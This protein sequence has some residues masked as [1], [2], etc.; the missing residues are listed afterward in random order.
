MF[1]KQCRESD[2]HL[3]DATVESYVQV[4]YLVEDD[5]KETTPQKVIRS[6]PVVTDDKICSVKP[7][8]STKPRH[9]PRTCSS[10]FAH[11]D[12]NDELSVHQELSCPE[13]DTLIYLEIHCNECSMPCSNSVDNFIQHMID[14]HEK[15]ANLLAL[16]CTICNTT[17]SHEELLQHHTILHEYHAVRLETGVDGGVDDTQI[18][19]DAPSKNEWPCSQCGKF[20]GSKLRLSMHIRVRFIYISVL[21]S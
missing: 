12:N 2:I 10:C 13:S 14:Q 7:P 6:S 11:F 17:F 3:R 8:N 16:S 5:G 18:D 15:P 1:R 19:H 20:F 21:L 4:E 9:N